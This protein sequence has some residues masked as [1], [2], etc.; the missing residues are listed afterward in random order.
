MNVVCVFCFFF[1]GNL[2]AF[3]GKRARGEVLEI[4][5]EFSFFFIHDRALLIQGLQQ[6]LRQRT[7]SVLELIVRRCEYLGLQKIMSRNGF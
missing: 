7:R 2:F 1:G 4:F 3:V 6:R 5:F